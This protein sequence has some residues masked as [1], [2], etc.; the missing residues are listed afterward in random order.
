LVV[1]GQQL[2]LQAGTPQQCLDLTLIAD[3]YGADLSGLTILKCL[4]SNCNNCK[5]DHTQCTECTTG[6]PPVQNRC[7][8][9]IGINFRKISQNANDVFLVA[10]VEVNLNSWPLSLSEVRA[11]LSTH[12]SSSLKTSIIENKPSAINPIAGALIQ[13]RIHTDSSGNIL[14][15]TTTFDELT[16]RSYL[17]SF[18]TNS[19]LVGVFDGSTY[20]IIIDNSPIEVTVDQTTGIGTRIMRIIGGSPTSS[21]SMMGVMAGLLILIPLARFSSSPRY[22]K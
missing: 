8:R 17:I 13:L 9:E 22:S 4:T 14:A 2:Y 18:F 1:N 21:P 5:F 12:L 10:S 19:V 11:F 7:V 3:G 15:E 20:T 16:G 6:L